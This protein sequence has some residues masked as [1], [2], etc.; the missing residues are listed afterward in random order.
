MKKNT[1]LTGSRVRTMT[2]TAIFAALAYA[3]TLVIHFPVGFLTLDLKDAVIAIGSMILGPVAALTTTALAALLEF[4]TIGDTGLYGLIMDVLSSLAFALPAALIYTQKKTLMGA[5]L[6]LSSAVITM[7]ATMMVAN[8]L[9]TP[10]FMGVTVGQVADMIPATF[11]PF[12]F[13]K[14]LL[15][16]GAVLL[17]YKPLSRALRHF[18]RDKNGASS[19]KSDP[20]RSLILA[21]VAVAIIVLALLLLF[22]VMDAGVDFGK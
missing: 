9:V 6:A 7:T 10:H 14:A 4:L 20:K 1:L 12:N 22:F 16:A 19:H 5:I 15:N 21:A 2:L 11:L 13:L 3:V 8:L 18:G 17:L